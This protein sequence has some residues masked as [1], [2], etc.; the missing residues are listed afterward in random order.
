MDAK[1]VLEIILEE[2]GKVDER[3]PGY[4]DELK[5]TVAEIIAIER[6]HKLVS[7]NVK[8]DIAAQVNRLGVELAN[9]FKRG[10]AS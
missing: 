4:R 2:V 7:R 1:R 5:E 8:Q 9:N 6:Q 10:G 3:Y